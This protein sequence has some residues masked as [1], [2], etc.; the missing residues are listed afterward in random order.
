MINYT[1]VLCRLSIRLLSEMYSVVWPTEEGTTMKGRVI[2]KEERE[3]GTTLVCVM[4][5]TDREVACQL[6]YYYSR[7][8]RRRSSKR[9]TV[10]FFRCTSPNIPLYTQTTRSKASDV[11]ITTQSWILHH[12]HLHVS[13]RNPTSFV[14][15]SEYFAL[16]SLYVEN[17]DL[18]WN[19]MA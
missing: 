15:M 9:G 19:Q 17:D 10:R 3:E 4:R 7:I 14:S 16:Q 13:H 1:Y 5:R 11:F 6:L 8:V 2:Y 18:E 12:P